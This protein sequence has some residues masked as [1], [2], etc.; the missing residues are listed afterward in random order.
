MWHAVKCYEEKSLI[1]L[2]C[3]FFFLFTCYISH[4][5]TIKTII[6]QAKWVPFCFSSIKLSLL[7]TLLTITDRI[8]TVGHT[9]SHI[10]YNILY[11]HILMWVGMGTN[12][13][14]KN[15][16]KRS[17]IYAFNSDRREHRIIYI[18][19]IRTIV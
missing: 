11:I 15:S 9:K 5:E 17:H 7:C 12:L 10:L 6:T 3:H 2:F 13:G 1:W 18:Y 4:V 16:K 8:R 14:K 19:V